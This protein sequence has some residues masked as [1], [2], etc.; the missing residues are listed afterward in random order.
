MGV[1]TREVE[2]HGMTDTGAS[3]CM[4][5]TNSM[6]AMGLTERVMMKCD[7][8]LYGADNSD[9]K[10]LGAVFVVITDIRTGQETRQLLYVCE[11][12][13]SLLLSLEAC[14]DLGLVGP[15]F[16][17]TE[18]VQ[19]AGNAAASVGNNPDCD[20]KCPVREMAPDVPIELP[21]ELT[22]DNIPRLEHWIRDF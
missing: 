12:A 11:R 17:D 13:A 1:R 19:V 22:P 10:L 18:S 16:P 4:S 6:R 15:D 8:R 21:L 3:V 14:V 5:G 2:D 7:L 20:C 9:I